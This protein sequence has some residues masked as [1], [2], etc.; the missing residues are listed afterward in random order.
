MKLRYSMVL[1]LTMGFVN[2]LLAEQLPKQSQKQALYRLQGRKKAS[3][4]KKKKAY[5]QSDLIVP[6][7]DL[8]QACTNKMLYACISGYK[9]PQIK[10]IPLTSLYQPE[11]K[12]LRFV[13]IVTSYNNAAWYKKNLTSIFSQKYTNYHVIYVDDASTD[14]TPDLVEK[15]VKEQGMEKHVTLIRNQ[16]QRRMAY[17]RYIAVHLSADT[18][19]CMALDG[20][21]WMPHDKVLSLY[22]KI[23]RDKNVWLTYGHFQIFPENKKFANY[24]GE[25]VSSHVLATNTIRKS[26]WVTSHFKTFYAWLFKAIEEESF[27]INGKF[28]EAATDFA[29][30]FPMVEMASFYTKFVSEVTYIYNRELG[31]LSAKGRLKQSEIF[32]TS[33]HLAQQVPYTPIYIGT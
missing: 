24:R 2:I 15:F 11:Q 6:H 27:K 18:D 32:K 1:L 25:A 10:K 33:H 3:D 7:I 9:T 8:N 16:S 19:I 5:Q 31:H 21:D 26:P 28:V 12:E 30:M 23:Y 22:N 29:M 13:F 17:N 4:K 20:D 14:G